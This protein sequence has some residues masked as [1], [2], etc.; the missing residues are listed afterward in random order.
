[1][2]VLLA[3]WF[4]CT[5][6]CQVEQVGMSRKVAQTGTPKADSD[7]CGWVVSGGLDVSDSRTA[8]QEFTPLALIAPCSVLAADLVIFSDEMRVQNKWSVAPP[9]M[10]ASFQFLL[11]TA[12]PARAPGVS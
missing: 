8:V 7:V 12:L 9:E 11:R 1:M 5:L 4:A 6:H 2:V 10:R 3:N